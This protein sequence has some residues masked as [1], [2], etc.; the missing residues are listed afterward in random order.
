MDPFHA[1]STA[2]ATRNIPPL[3]EAPRAKVRSRALVASTDLEKALN[4]VKEVTRGAGPP[5]V[6]MA[7][8]PANSPGQPVMVVAD[9]SPMMRADHHQRAKVPLVPEVMERTQLMLF[10]L[11]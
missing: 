8:R 2:A 10:P 5:S 4:A 3:K 6:K 1:L 7:G 9:R 11:V